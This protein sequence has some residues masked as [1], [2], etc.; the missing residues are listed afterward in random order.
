MTALMGRG[1]VV[2]LGMGVMGLL[3]CGAQWMVAPLGT[4][5]AWLFGSLFW[6]GLSMGSVALVMIH[7]LTGGRWG[8]AIRRILEAAIAP[9]WIPALAFLPLCFALPELYPW[10]RPAE[11]AADTVLAHRQPYFS[12][13]AWIVRAALFLG[14]WLA[15]CWNLR[16]L[17]REQDRTGVSALRSLRR[18]SGPGLLVYPLVATFAY[19]D[20]IM[21]LEKHWYS[22]IFMALLCVGG[23]LCALSLA[24]VML[25]RL[26]S[27]EILAKYRQPEVYRSLGSLLLAFV[28]L[29]TYLAFGQFLIIWSGNLPHEISWYLQRTEQGWGWVVGLV[30]LLHF[31]GPFF[32]LLSRQAKGKGFVLALVGGAILASHLFFDAWLV[33][34]SAQFSTFN[35][36]T[37]GAPAAIGG[38]W[39]WRFFS[40]LPA[41]PLVPSIDPRLPQTDE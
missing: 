37:V 4:F 17:S 18:F 9:F 23:M 8:F 26:G 15:M 29:W 12:A 32:V 22:T 10:A 20:W 13:E 19:L 36:A 21:A 38:F 27:E 5:H 35:F 33:L 24:I 34:P 25:V 40:V 39:C 7:H 31:A 2:G 1:R 41:L 30:L 3:V 16:R 11:V 6:L 14:V 28:M